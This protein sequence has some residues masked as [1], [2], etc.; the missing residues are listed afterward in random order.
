MPN[1]K[2]RKMNEDIGVI[3]L[4]HDKISTQIFNNYPSKGR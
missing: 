3:K 1:K 4:R 2:A